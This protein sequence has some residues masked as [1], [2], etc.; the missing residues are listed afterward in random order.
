MKSSN[1]GKAAKE[2]QAYGEIFL[3]TFINMLVVLGQSP[4]RYKKDSTQTR[5]LFWRPLEFWAFAGPFGLF[6]RLRIQK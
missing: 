4:G 2:I 5:M 3:N 1:T 6:A